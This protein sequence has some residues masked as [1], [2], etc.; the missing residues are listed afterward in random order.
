MGKNERDLTERAEETLDRL[1]EAHPDARIY[2]DYKN[3]LQ[4]LVA[5][6]LAAQC[7]DERVNQVT[8][9]LFDRWPTAEDLAEADRGELEEV[10]HST[11]TFR[12]KAASI[13]EACRVIVE[14][15]AG[16]VPDEIEQ[17]TQIQGVGR[18]TASVVVGNALGKPAMPVDTH[19]KRVATRLGLARGKTVPRIE[20]ELRRAIPEER[21]TRSTQLMGTHGR[22]IC[23]A[24][25]PAC[26]DCPVNDLCDYYREQQEGGGK[27]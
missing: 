4:L 5:T 16:E 19:V 21:W 23:T 3:P 15:H 13:Q 18:K 27:E 20:K 7:T 14:E 1:E 6:I 12:Q 8:P 10:I 9:E 17:L 25:S 11:G 2:L 22:R 24:R 26:E